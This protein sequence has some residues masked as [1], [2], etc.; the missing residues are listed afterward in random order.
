MCGEH[1]ISDVRQREQR[2]G[3][4]A[5]YYSV[6]A[7]STAP[8]RLV[9]C[10]STAI[11]L[12]DAHLAVRSDIKSEFTRLVKI[13]LVNNEPAGESATMVVGRRSPSIMDG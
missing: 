3:G 8:L 2:T 9:Y 12:S 1:G 4:G 7:V 5:V 13:Y 6:A 11:K 10:S